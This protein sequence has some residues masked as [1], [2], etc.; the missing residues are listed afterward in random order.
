MNNMLSQLQAIA[1]E[2]SPKGTYVD[3]SERVGLQEVAKVKEVYTA[4]ATM[5]PQDSGK[6]FNYFISNLNPDKLQKD[7]AKEYWSIFQANYPGGPEAAKTAAVERIQAGLKTKASPVEKEFYLRDAVATMPEW[8]KDTFYPELASAQMAVSNANLS[9]AQELFKM[10][11]VNKLK[12]IDALDPEVSKATHVEDFL[13]LES[14]NLSGAAR[15]VNGRFGMVDKNGSFILA[16]ELQDRKEI[17]ED[18]VG[19]PSVAEQQEVINLVKDIADFQIE[20]NLE[21]TRTRIA[22]DN[23]A[24]KMKAMDN[25]RKGFYNKDSWETAFSMIDGV[26]PV[27][28]VRYAIEGEIAR[29]RITNPTKL[30]E[31]IYE[32]L[33]KYRNVLG[34]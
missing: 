16:S 6:A 30:Q 13:K 17:F 10:A 4:G 31:T 5:Y 28:L 11:T 2:T 24:I 22:N 32:T 7:A 21:R 33:L 20:K 12:D 14:L 1:T 3:T 15:V 19:A 26:K 23:S 9:K 27:D 8:A 29:G 34:A 18:G 25:L